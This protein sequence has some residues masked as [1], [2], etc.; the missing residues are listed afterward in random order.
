MIYTKDD[1]IK[2]KSLIL[3][4]ISR[5]AIKRKYPSAYLEAINNKVEEFFSLYDFVPNQE[6]LSHP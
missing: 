3:S 4:K 1:Y 2:E 5:T 6:L